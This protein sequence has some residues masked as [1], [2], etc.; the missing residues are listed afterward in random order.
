MFKAKYSYLLSKIKEVIKK[1]PAYGIRRIKQALLDDYN[2][3]IGRDT[4]GKL[5]KIEGLSLGRNIKKRKRSML[6]KILIMLSDKVNLLI[7]TEIDRPLQAI[8]SDISKIVYNNGRSKCYLA[9]HKDV[10]GQVVYGYAVMELM[11]LEI[12]MKS[13]EK[14]VSYLKKKLG[15]RYVKILA[16]I[17]FHQDQ[18]S[19]YTS[20]IYTARIMELGKL[21]YSSPGTPTE[22]P[23]QE[24]F[25]GRFKDE[26]RDELYELENFKEVKKFIE[27]K[28]NYYNNQRLHT[29]INYQ[30]PQFFTK[31]YLKFW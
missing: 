7:R 13:L 8:T 28:I 15:K 20:Y 12:V 17:I 21:S 29:S 25:F 19:Q 22:N 4:L 6:Q 9:I 14:A 5:L 11:E 1:N 27:K 16:K 18:G 24:S 31:S 23:G 10:F 26:W 3:V 2:E 30:T